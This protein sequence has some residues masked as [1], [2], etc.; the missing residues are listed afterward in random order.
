MHLSVPQCGKTS[1]FN[2]LVLTTNVNHPWYRQSA[3]KIKTETDY[4]DNRTI[5]EKVSPEL[6]P[7][8]PNVLSSFINEKEWERRRR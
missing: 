5:N 6:W 3:L 4:K 2:K 7:V 1:V 8:S